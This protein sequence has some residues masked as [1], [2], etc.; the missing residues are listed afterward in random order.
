V[1]SKEKVRNS[2]TRACVGGDPMTSTIH[3]WFVQGVYWMVV[4]SILL[5]IGY[6]AGPVTASMLAWI[7]FA[8]EGIARKLDALRHATSESGDLIA[9]LARRRP[10]MDHAALRQ[11]RQEYSGATEIKGVQI[12]K[13]AMTAADVVRLIDALLVTTD[14]SPVMPPPEA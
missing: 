10:H 11:L 3:M 2:A 9:H 8:K 5:V 4:G 1:A 6:E 14:P 7:V 12:V 13:E